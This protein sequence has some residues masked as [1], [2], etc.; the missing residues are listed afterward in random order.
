V[1]SPPRPD[2]VRALVERV[3]RR[4]GAPPLSDQALSRLESADVHHFQA[5]TGG[6]LTGYAQLDA[7]TLEIVAEPDAIDE[8]FSAAER[9]SDVIDV[10]SHGRRSP[11]AAAAEARGYVRDRVLWQL[12]RPPAV[13]APVDPPAGVSIRP[14]VP[15]QD[16]QSWLEVNAAAFAGHGEQGHLG[17]SDLLAR[18]HE[19]WFDPAG[20]L[21]AVDGHDQLLGFHWT[22]VHADGAGEVYVLG[23]APAS[24]GTGLGQALLSAGLRHLGSDRVILLYVDDSNQGAKRLYEKA[25]FA[26]YDA[27]V[28]LR[29]PASP[30]SS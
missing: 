25:G 9:V 20:F 3:E 21:L 26:E 23:V 18:E 7:T 2:E 10:W 8:L 4:D 15:G 5:R 28:Q 12:R 27:D 22:K 30:V 24:Q 1:T 16:E 17:L 13:A 29:S 19:D 6:R 14:F 11:I